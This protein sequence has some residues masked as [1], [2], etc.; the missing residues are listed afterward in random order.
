MGPVRKHVFHRILQDEADASSPKLRAK[1]RFIPENYSFQSAGTDT[2]NERAAY[3]IEVVPRIEDK[4]LIAGRVWVDA[5]EYAVLRIEGKPA[6]N[7]SFWTRS[8][9]FVHTNQK[10]GPFW[11]PVSNRSIT[12]VR[13]FGRTEM[14]IRYFDYLTNPRVLSASGSSTPGRRPQ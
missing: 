8:V 7:P 5:E 11:L 9:H 6:K 1:S 13:I 4:F 2:V 3:V 12:D 14:T 10:N